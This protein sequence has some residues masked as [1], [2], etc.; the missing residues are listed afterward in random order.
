MR[1]PLG[2]QLH[3]PRNST[4]QNTPTSASHQSRKKKARRILVPVL[5]I[6]L[7]LTTIA[8][9]LYFLTDSPQ[10][11]TA[12]PAT[13]VPR[14]KPSTESPPSVSAPAKETTPKAPETQPT[15]LTKPVESPAPA[16]GLTSLK[17]LDHFLAAKTL[18][19]RLPWI[20]TRTSR[21]ELES[22]IVARPLPATSRIDTD[23]QETNSI[24]KVTD[25]FYNVDFQEADG[26]V[27]PQTILVRTRGSS[28][29]KV[30]IDPFLDLYGGRLKKYA[31]TPSDRPANFEVIVSAGAFCYDE[32]VP[33]R[34]K[35]LTLKLLARD[36]TKEIS[37]AFF[38]KRSRIGEML[39]RD[40]GLSYGQAKACTV[41]LRWNTEE[42]RNKPYLEAINIKS[43]N[44]NP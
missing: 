7:V 10:T 39:E 13:G 4:V 17:V 38:G 41:T 23:Y 25:I 43:L 20:E 16:P 35:K 37:R 30:V 24:E 1:K 28:E 5:F 15:A 29:P 9:I 11:S 14:E 40:F 8:G 12:S 31:S 32:H 27:N 42:D 21:E 19:E 22:S 36:N 2:K 3:D 44:W 6:L 34:D 26:T 33:N 18:E